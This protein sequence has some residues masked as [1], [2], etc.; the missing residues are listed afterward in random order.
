[1]SCGNR[2]IADLRLRGAGLA[3]LAVGAMVM[4][5]LFKGAPLPRGHAVAL[6]EVGLAAIGFLGLSL[7]TALS[8]LGARLLDQ[9]ELSERWTRN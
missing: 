8:A 4:R 1:M 2:I 7:G 5:H 6:A 3:L 9:V